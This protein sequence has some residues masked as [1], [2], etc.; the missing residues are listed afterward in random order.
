[1]GHLLLTAMLGACTG[2]AEPAELVVFGDRVWTG[3][4]ERP[5][6]EGIAVAGDR[7]VAVGAREELMARVGDGTRVV[8]I[9]GS[10]VVPGF[11]DAHVHFLEGGF[12][13]SSVQ[14]RD[15]S[16]P[17]E[18]GRRIGE[19]AAGLP[20]GTWITGGDWDHEHW[21]GELPDRDWVDAMT[22]D[23]PV[24]V[25]RLDGHMALANSAALRAA[26]ID[27]S[28][29][30]PDGGEIVRDAD[31]LPTGVLKDNAMTLVDAVRPDPGT[32]LEDEAL[33]AAMAH[34][35]AQGVT[36]V[37][38]MGTWED[39]EV[40]ERAR[41]Q[42]R[43]GTRIRAAVPLSSWER[44][45]GRIERS[46]RGDD[47]LRIDSL[48]GFVDGSL[49]SHTAAFLDAYADAPGEHGLLVNDPDELHR[50][51]SGADGAGLQVNVHAI[52]DRAIRTLLDIYERV[53]ADHG[54][55]DRR[56]R[57]EH[58]QHVHPDDLPR[59]AQLGVIASMQPYHAIDDGRWAGRVIGAERSRTTY[60]VRSLLDAGARVA[61]GSDWFV[62]PPTPLEGIYA[63][64]TRRTLD[65]A[66]PDGWVPEQRI[67]VE[68]AL[69]AYTLDAAYASFQDGS[70][71]SLEVGK[72]ADMT[73]LGRDLTA[74]PPEQ[75]GDVPVLLTIVGGRVVHDGR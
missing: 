21:G 68:E 39:L 43:L 36:S 64:V 46:G 49:G 53:D 7:I 47:W 12:R 30:E 60:A 1:M 71:G 19:F 51:I 5:R 10:M 17:E 22:P 23:N 48:K 38:H 11:I 65:G 67:S 72:L 74:I 18:F 9:A 45:A 42:G 66:H 6:A 61:F 20:A 73:V 8:D 59:F 28:T 33:D 70:L 3:D 54:A 58:A 40:F 34:V 25:N 35:A 32:G 57:I 29:P 24:W 37:H 62:A 13:L 75:L 52:G 69:R 15:A 4:P 55:A 2:G 56:W 31:G 27:A 50:W 26:G 63:A 44:L 14:L 16:T 41:R